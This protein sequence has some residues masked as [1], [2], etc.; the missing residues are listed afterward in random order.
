VTH[1]EITERRAADKRASRREGQ[2]FIHIIALLRQVLQIRMSKQ[3]TTQNNKKTTTQNKAK[4][5]PVRYRK[6]PRCDIWAEEWV[7]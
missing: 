4:G 5:I 7:V 6:N 3:N 1:D 2:R